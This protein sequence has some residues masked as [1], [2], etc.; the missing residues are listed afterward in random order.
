MLINIR[1]KFNMI[2]DLVL[3]PIEFLAKKLQISETKRNDWINVLLADPSK[4]DQACAY[5]KRKDKQQKILC[6]GI[7]VVLPLLILLILF[8]PIII[9][10]KI[11]LIIV[12]LFLLYSYN[13]CFDLGLQGAMSCAREDFFNYEQYDSFFN[14]QFPRELASK[15][16]SPVLNYIFSNNIDQHSI[17]KTLAILT[18]QLQYDPS[19]YKSLDQAEGVGWYWP[20][21]SQQINPYWLKRY[22]GEDLTD[23]KYLPYLPKSQRLTELLQ[24][25]D[26]Y[27]HKCLISKAKAF[28]PKNAPTIN[29]VN[30]GNALNNQHRFKLIYVNKHNLE[31]YAL[32]ANP[33]DMHV[34]KIKYYDSAK[35]FKNKHNIKQI[36][37]YAFLEC[38]VDDALTKLQNGR[39]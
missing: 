3:A 23:T 2:S 21:H 9:K 8:L 16:A 5:F 37:V 13:W 36:F 17:S 1:K 4:L 15:Q 14:S 33:A 7:N 10:L 18:N 38:D 34:Y 30:L 27:L 22:L 39:L 28:V 20:M 6:I 35:S 32:S 19:Q 12:D 11:A 24:K 25:I 31:A 26:K 29:I